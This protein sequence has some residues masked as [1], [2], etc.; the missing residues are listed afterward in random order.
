[1]KTT[2]IITVIAALFIAISFTSCE[3]IKGKGE[4]V[5]QARTVTG[6]SGVSLSMP[7][8]VYFTTGPDYLLEI[9]AQQNILDRIETKI[10]GNL[11][12]IKLKHGVNIRDYKSIRVYVTAPG[13]NHLDVSG[14]GDLYS[15][16][17]WMG[18]DL[19]VNISG[20][21]SITL[22]YVEAD[23][24]NTTISGSG[25]IKALGGV[26]GRGELKISGS[27]SI[28]VQYMKCDDVYTRTSG[29][30]DTYV[31]AIN[32][33]DVTIS[34]SGSVYYLGTPV[35]NTHISGSG[36]IRQL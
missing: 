22:N 33:L 1:M 20:S 29:S 26:V 24:F 36:N 6:Y 10:K 28:E 35:I 9:H 4:V 30:G 13:V 2:K 7:A 8:Q 15:D 21:G 27:G 12:V 14:S 3:K 23:R 19:S 34:G 16:N 25:N 31:H 5:T 18:S 17:D 11:L 32:L